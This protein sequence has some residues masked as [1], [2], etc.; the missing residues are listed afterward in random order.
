MIHSVKQSESY[1]EPDLPFFSPCV[2]S[3][4]PVNARGERDKVGCE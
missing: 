2:Y 3:I 1:G 4:P